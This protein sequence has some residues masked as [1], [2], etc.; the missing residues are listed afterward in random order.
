MTMLKPAATA[1][2]DSSAKRTA[3]E[4]SWKTQ[5]TH[6]GTEAAFVKACVAK[7]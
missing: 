4:Q 5:K 7:G 3:C 2:M 1:K 6:T